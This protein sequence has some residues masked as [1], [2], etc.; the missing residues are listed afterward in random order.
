M[1]GARDYGAS[2][3]EGLVTD[4]VVGSEEFV[5]RVRQLIRGDRNEQKPVR[6]LESV[7]VSWQ[8]ITEAVAKVWREPWETAS[9]RHG[10]PAR[11][12]AMLIGRR[13]AGMSLRQIGDAIGDLSYPAVSDALRRTTKSL[14]KDRSLQKRR[15]RVLDYL[16]L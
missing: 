15:K 13:Y 5:K 16:N 11:E 7:P 10:N 6:Q 2:W 8:S 1:I 9:Q 12:V 3:K 4:L 14:Q